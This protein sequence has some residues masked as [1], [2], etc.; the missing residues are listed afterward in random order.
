MAARLTTA[1]DRITNRLINV[2]LR[3]DPDVWRHAKRIAVL[4]LAFAVW[5]VLYAAICAALGAWQCGFL[6]L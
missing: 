5:V 4:N 2:S 6:T 3:Q 1:I